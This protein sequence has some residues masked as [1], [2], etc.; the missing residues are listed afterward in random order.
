MSMHCKRREKFR[1]RGS[2]TGESLGPMGIYTARSNAEGK[3]INP[4]AVHPHTE[5]TYFSGKL[6]CSFQQAILVMISSLTLL[7]HL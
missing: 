4:M 1:H 2:F 5:V 6:R 3:Y 7:M